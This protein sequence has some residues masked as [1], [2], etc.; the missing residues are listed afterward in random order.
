MHKLVML[1]WPGVLIAAASAA[2]AQ[3]LNTPGPVPMDR[4]CPAD[5]ELGGLPNSAVVGSY[6]IPQPIARDA[7][8]LLVHV[9]MYSGNV[10]PNGPRSYRIISERQPYR[11][12]SHIFYHWGYPG[13]AVNSTSQD[14]WLPAPAS[15]QLQVALEGGTPF[16]EGSRGSL[17]RLI[18]YVRRTGVNVCR[19]G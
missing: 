7:A 5:A 19:E 10:R 15:G 8:W 16:A 3:P 6:Q 2:G 13:A 18:G 12:F 1:A 9:Q 17:I 4:Y 14:Y 11:P